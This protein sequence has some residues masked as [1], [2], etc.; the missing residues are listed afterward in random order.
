MVLKCTSDRLLRFARRTIGY[1]FTFFFYLT[2][3]TTNIFYSLVSVLC[4]RASNRHVPSASAKKVSCLLK[5]FFLLVLS[6]FWYCISSVP[7]S[8]RLTGT[9]RLRECALIVAVLFS[10]L[11]AVIFCCC[12][13]IG[14]F[15]F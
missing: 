9:Q 12:L 5:G 13:N 3:T 14:S 6:F 11:L 8:S 2:N 10:I 7:S 1:M 15:I 4:Q